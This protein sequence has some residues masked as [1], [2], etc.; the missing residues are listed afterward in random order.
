M[1]REHPAGALTRLTLQTIG[2]RRK[3][4]APGVR[5][6]MEPMASG[7][8]TLK[9]PGAILSLLLLSLA[10]SQ[11]I[12]HTDGSPGKVANTVAGLDAC[13]PAQH[14]VELAIAALGGRDKL[15]SIKDI[16]LDVLSNTQL[17]EQ[18]YRQAPFI[19]SY[20]RDHLT[21]DLAGRR[22]LN[23]A[24]SF[25]PE[26]DPKQAES[27]SLLIVTPAG[28]VYRDDNKDS[29]CSGAALDNSN[30]TLALG[31]IRLLLTAAAAADLHMAPAE[32]LRSTPHAVVAF[33]WNRIPVR[34]LIN[35]YNHLPDAVETVQQFRDFWYFW[36]DV[37]QRVYFDNW[38]LFAGVVYPTNQVTERNGLT[39]S[40]SQVFDLEFNVPLDE[41]QLTV[42]ATAAQH[43]TESKGWKRS[44]PASDS[45]TLAPGVDLYPGSWNSTLVREPDGIVILESP[46]S[47]TFTESLF[48]EARRKYPD[49]PIKAIVST[50]DSWPHVGGI[51]F[52]VAQGIPV[53]ILDLN[54]ALLERMLAAPHTIDPDALTH[55]QR[56]PEWQIV[57]GKTVVSSGANRMELYPLRG[58]ATERQFMVYFPEHRLLYASD[59][60]V[61]NPDHSLYDPELMREVVAAVEREHLGVDT[62]FAMHQ[63]PMPWAQALDLVHKATT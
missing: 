59:T 9:L 19:T 3:I 23:A 57:S 51:R 55:S 31:P 50:S 58:A 12:A 17:A 25:W 28:G 52:D 11:V 5:Q 37:A 30:Q 21:L 35:P 1:N 46:I 39:W 45:T 32:T 22:V 8:D 36:G 7:S 40:S 49:V 6:G 44:L 60:L 27:D 47:S 10:T 63:A 38:Q 43:S 33:S 56:R 15:E 26:S 4:Q 2:P 41:K 16:R 48:A 18:S 62:V 61:I 13:A 54:R 29:P 14:C 24:H 42:D 53:Y 34:I 20:E